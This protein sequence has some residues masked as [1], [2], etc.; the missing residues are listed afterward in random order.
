MP[1]LIG[2]NSTE[3]WMLLEILQHKQDDC[4][5]TDVSGYAEFFKLNVELPNGDKYYIEE[6]YERI[7]KVKKLEN[8]QQEG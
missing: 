3:Y 5:F 2:L 1:H 7:V 4:I 8:E 6:V